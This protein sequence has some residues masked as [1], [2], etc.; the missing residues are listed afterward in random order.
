M[1]SAEHVEVARELRANADQLRRMAQL[2]RADRDYVA[3]VLQRAAELDEEADGMEAAGRVRSGN[4]R[5]TG[6]PMP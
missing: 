5:G 6:G 1:A 2:K 3:K 4:G